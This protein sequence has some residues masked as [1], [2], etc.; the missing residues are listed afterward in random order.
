[1]NGRKLIYAARLTSD[2]LT[3]HGLA[4]N[5]Q[6]THA[7][8]GYCFE[9]HGLRVPLSTEGPSVELSIQ[10]HPACAGTPSQLGQEK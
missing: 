8:V 10:T 7:D 6:N 1:M 2:W 4:H 5:I 9:D 3:E